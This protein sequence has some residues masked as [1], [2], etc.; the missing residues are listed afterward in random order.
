MKGMVASMI[1]KVEGT[2]KFKNA[3]PMISIIMINITRKM[4]VAETTLATV[5][6]F[7]KRAFVLNLILLNGYPLHPSAG[8]LVVYRGA[9]I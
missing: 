2:G 8:G 5:I 4:S 6:I 3:R 7:R 9:I 1:S